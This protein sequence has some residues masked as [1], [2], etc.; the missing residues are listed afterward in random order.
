[1]GIESSGEGLQLDFEF[2][3]LKLPIQVNEKSAS[4]MFGTDITSVL[5]IPLHLPDRC[6][7]INA[8]VANPLPVRFDRDADTFLGW[9]IDMGQPKVSITG[10]SDGNGR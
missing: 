4:R 1:M 5:G 6:G 2:A 10:K 9:F 7:R 3:L 8:E